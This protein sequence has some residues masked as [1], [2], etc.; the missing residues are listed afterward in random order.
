M[1]RARIPPAVNQIEA[2]PYLQQRDLLAW[3]KQQVCLCLHAAKHGV[4]I[5]DGVGNRHHRLLA[6]REQYL[7]HPSVSIRQPH[8]AP[9]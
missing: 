6:S 9:S 5:A 3:S 7:Q 4:Y 8:N 1:R 2:H